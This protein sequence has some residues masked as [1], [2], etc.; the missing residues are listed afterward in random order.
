VPEI[1]AGSLFV[2]VDACGP[3]M[4]KDE[5]CCR[6]CEEEGLGLSVFRSS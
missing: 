2:T 3:F 4:N 6:L 5:S 1:G